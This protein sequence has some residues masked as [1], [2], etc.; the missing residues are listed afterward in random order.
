MEK[1]N[2]NMFFETSAFDGENVDLVTRILL[3]II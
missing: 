1:N 2:L 3:I